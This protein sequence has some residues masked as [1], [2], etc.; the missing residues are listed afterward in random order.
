MRE[1]MTADS[2]PDEGCIQRWATLNWNLYRKDSY[3]DSK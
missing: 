2:A 1:I 3:G